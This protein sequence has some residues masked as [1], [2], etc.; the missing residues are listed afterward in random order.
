M[1][2]QMITQIT[3]LVVVCCMCGEETISPMYDD[4]DSPMCPNCYKEYSGDN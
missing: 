2:K 1:R 3:Y 4:V